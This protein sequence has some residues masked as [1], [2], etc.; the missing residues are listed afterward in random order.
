MIDSKDELLM[1]KERKS[2]FEI[3][4]LIADHLTGEEQVL[5]TLSEA[6][7]LDHTTLERYLK[8]ISECQ[9]LFAGKT[10][11]YKEQKIGKKTYKSCW[12]TEK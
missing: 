5:Y 4:R 7:G 8:L 9:V 10:V 11:H 2:G 6:T 3:I 1:G 12:V